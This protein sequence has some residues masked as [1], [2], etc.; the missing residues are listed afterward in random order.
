MKFK[1]VKKDVEKAYEWIKPIICAKSDKIK[2]ILLSKRH[3]FWTMKTAI[4]IQNLFD[5]FDWLLIRHIFNIYQ[6]VLIVR[7]KQTDYNSTINLCQFINSIIT[8]PTARGYDLPSANYECDE[9]PMI[10]DLLD[11]KKF[12]NDDNYKINI[13]GDKWAGCL[14]VSL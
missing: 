2:E 13:C 7:C 4:E 14:I 3:K 1:D 8:Y 10:R 9:I 5:D 11:M 6:I 12:N